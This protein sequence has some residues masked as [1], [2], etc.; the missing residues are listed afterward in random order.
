MTWQEAYDAALA[1]YDGNQDRARAF[2]DYAAGSQATQPKAATKPRAAAPVAKPP[3]APKPPPSLVDAVP[4]AAPPVGALTFPAQVITAERPRIPATMVSTVTVPVPAGEVVGATIR[5]GQDAVVDGLGSAL[6]TAQDVYMAPAKALAGVYG[7][8]GR[9]EEAID[10]ATTR[11]A[12]RDAAVASDL[13]AV[14]SDIRRGYAGASPA[15]PAPPAPVETLVGA[16]PLTPVVASP[17][18]P[19]PAGS[20]ADLRAQLVGLGLDPAKV[21]MVPESR[22]KDYLTTLKARANTAGQ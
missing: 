9:T 20:A 6:R 2:A 11:Q 14:W 1:R 12:E 22:L 5:R 21:A 19:P 8:L 13:P 4:P 10:K 15:R 3:P 7:G 16:V 18:P 17:P